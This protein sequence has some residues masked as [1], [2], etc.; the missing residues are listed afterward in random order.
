MTTTGSSSR[1]QGCHVTDFGTNGSGSCFKGGDGNNCNGYSNGG[2]IARD[3]SGL[4]AKT[5]DHRHIAA[6]LRQNGG[7]SRSVGSGSGDSSVAREECQD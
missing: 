1:S 6:I 2:G 3:E 5:I 4:C 7:S